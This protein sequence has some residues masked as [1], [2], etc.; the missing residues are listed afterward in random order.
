MLLIRRG[1]VFWG[2]RVKISGNDRPN[3]GEA[4]KQRQPFVATEGREV[5]GTIF[6]TQLS[7]GHHAKITSAVSG[8]QGPIR[9]TLR[10]FRRDHKPAIR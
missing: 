3:F 10:R 6:L 9:E 2:D 5:H 8:P 1:P 4:Y 7:G